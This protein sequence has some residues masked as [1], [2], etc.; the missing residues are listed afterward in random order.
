[1]VSTAGTTTNTTTC[2][3]RTRTAG[4][5][6]T[7]DG[8]AW[9]A[10]RCSLDRHADR[11]QR[12]RLHR[13]AHDRR[14]DSVRDRRRRV[15]QDPVRIMHLLQLGPTCSPGRQVPG[16]GAWF[17]QYHLAI[18]FLLPAIPLCTELALCRDALR[19]APWSACA[20]QSPGCAGGEHDLA[21]DR[22]V[23]QQP[24]RRSRPTQRHRPCEHGL[25]GAVDQQR[26]HRDQVLPI[27]CG[28]RLS[29]LQAE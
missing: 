26:Q 15:D 18:S 23:L 3:A 20:S 22:A 19:G 2:A 17:R 8:H 4:A 1:M 11:R 7:A 29:R 14:Y 10:A 28:C 16:R 6:L 5:L 25:D 12:S 9:C 24:L 27:A 21:G 13:I